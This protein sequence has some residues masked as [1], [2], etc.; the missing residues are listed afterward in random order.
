MNAET[1]NA[2]DARG[3]TVDQGLR[4]A[5]VGSQRAKE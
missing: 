3:I 5:T 2:P 4:I 1:G